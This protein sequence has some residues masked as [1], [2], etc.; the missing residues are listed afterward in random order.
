[1]S[2]RHRHWFRMR[3]SPMA[4]LKGWWW[5]FAIVICSYLFYIPLVHNKNVSR[6]ELESRVAALEYEKVLAVEEQEMLLLRISSQ[7]DPCWI[8]MMLMRALGVVP[9]GQVKVHFQNQS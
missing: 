3:S 6:K 8:E 2:I 9:E 4:F 5:V 7:S 1:M